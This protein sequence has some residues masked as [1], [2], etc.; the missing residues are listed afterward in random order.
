MK[1]LKNIS[2][3]L[4]L[5]IIISSSSQCSSAQKLEKN[6]SINFGDVYCKKWISGIKEGG[7]GTNLFIPIIKS[8]KNIQLEKSQKIFLSHPTTCPNEIY[9]LGQQVGISFD[10][11]TSLSSHS[12]MNIDELLP[13]ISSIR[14]TMTRARKERNN[15]YGS[16]EEG[17]D[18]LATYGGMSSVA[19]TAA[20]SIAEDRN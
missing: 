19:G 10:N 15:G 5:L 3:S 1:L 7:S 12:P 9:N 17:R 14:T 18:H 6:S 2:F 20:A 13:S 8:N 11:N 16:F 4:V